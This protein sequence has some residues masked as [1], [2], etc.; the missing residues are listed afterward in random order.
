MSVRAGR[1]IRDFDF[2][3][4]AVA[5]ALVGYGAALIYSG[6]LTTYGRSGWAALSHPVGRQLAYAALGLIIFAALARMDYRSLGSVAAGLYV[7]GV[8]ALVFVL[9]VGGAAYGSRRWIMLGG[10][11]IQASEIA[12]V[13]VIIALARYLADHQEDIQRPR[14]FLTSL[15]MAMVPAGLVFAEPDLGSAV[16][17]AAVWLGMVAVAGARPSHLVLLL[18]SAVSAIPFVLVGLVNDYQRERIRLWL[19]PANDPLGSGFNILQAQISI[20]SGRLW[21]KGF[22]HGTQTQL[23]YLR[24]Q[25]TDYIFSVLG[26]ELGFMGAMLL[27]G[28]FIVLLFRGLRVAGVASDLFGRLV[29]VGVVIFILSQVF[30]NIGVNVRVFPVTGIPLPLISQGG[31]SLVSVFAALGILESILLHRRRFWSF[32]GAVERR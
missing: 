24:T 12:K 23:D 3:L 1:F 4:L 9:V 10:T 8:A 26:E 22:T 7:A 13:L 31:S 19:D 2:L 25:T 6:S 16:I 27:F 32:G 17:F 15:A 28:L 20:G 18:G 21:G 5:L 14:V 11:Q 29:A 30:I